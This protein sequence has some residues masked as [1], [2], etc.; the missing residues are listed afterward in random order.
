LVKGIPLVEKG[1]RGDFDHTLGP[2]I[3]NFN[4]ILVVQIAAYY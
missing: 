4:Q 2:E 1:T 3:K